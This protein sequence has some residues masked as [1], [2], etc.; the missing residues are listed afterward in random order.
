[1]VEKDLKIHIVSVSKHLA[2]SFLQIVDFDYKIKSRF[3][4]IFFL[5]NVYDFEALCCN[6]YLFKQLIQFSSSVL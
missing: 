2:T 1:M 4:A 6:K 5:K 3:F